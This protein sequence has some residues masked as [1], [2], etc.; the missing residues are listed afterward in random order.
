MAKGKT[1]TEILE[2]YL[3][4]IKAVKSNISL[5]KDKENVDLPEYQNLYN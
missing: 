1:P 5:I 4:I 3:P 2:E